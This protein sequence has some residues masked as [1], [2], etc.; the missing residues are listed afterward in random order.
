MIDES[1]DYSC[2]VNE[3]FYHTYNYVINSTH[4]PGSHWYHAHWHGATA[5]HVNGGM[6]GGI[7]MLANPEINTTGHEPDIPDSQDHWLIT[8]FA[9]FVKN[10][11]CNDTIMYN[12][13]Y[14][15]GA[16]GAKHTAIEMKEYPDRYPDKLFNVRG[17]FPFLFNV[18]SYCWINCKFKSD[19]ATQWEYTD[20]K[21]DTQFYNTWETRN[22]SET[23][24]VNGQNTVKSL[25]TLR[26]Y[27]LCTLK[28]TFARG[29][30]F[31]LRVHS[32][33]QFCDF[34]HLSLC[35]CYCDK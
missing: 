15:C 30:G 5:L 32:T 18:Q 2:S 17:K 3:S 26:L 10:Q 21:H 35:F 7:R 8:S 29:F 1:D 31:A 25:F 28:I 27:F 12:E 16:Q 6:Y 22:T 14:F 13:S 34:W 20:V 23:F 24:L 33:S 19:Q 11:Y 9:W 4:Y